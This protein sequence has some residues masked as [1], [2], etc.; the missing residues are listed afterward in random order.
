MENKRKHDRRECNSGEDGNV[1]FAALRIER[2]MADAERR[3]ADDE[4]IKNHEAEVIR[5]YYE[6]EARAMREA[7]QGLAKSVFGSKEKKGD[8]EDEKYIDNSN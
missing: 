7:L 6:E 3:R 4:A 8:G 5:K 1:L 2:R